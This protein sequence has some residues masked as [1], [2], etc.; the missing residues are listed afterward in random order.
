[1]SIVGCDRLFCVKLTVPLPEQPSPKSPLQLTNE[2]LSS[3][4]SEFGLR[5]SP[6]QFIE[7]PS[8][9]YMVQSTDC[10]RSQD[11]NTVVV[12]FDGSVVTVTVERLGALSEPENFRLL[13]TELAAKLSRELQTNQVQSDY[14][15]RH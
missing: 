7:V 13:R 5:C 10:F 3:I 8:P 15:C 1:M 6:A 11:S 2:L 4:A 9:G 14:P 12:T